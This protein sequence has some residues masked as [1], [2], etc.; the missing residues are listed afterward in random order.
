MYCPSC[1]S[2]VAHGLTYCNQC[3][4]KLAPTQTDIAKTTEVSDSLVWAIVAI[5][6]VG[7][8]ATIGLMAVM[9]NELHFDT[10]LILFF[11]I[12]SF[13]LMTGIEAVFIWMLLRRTRSPKDAT[14]IG[15]KQKETKELAGAP[16]R[17]LAEPMASV[18]EETTRAF[19]PVYEKRK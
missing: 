15:R 2:A 6:V 14:A 7:I 18:T 12:L 13:A 10:S 9:K 3:G 16:H 8:G 1:G 11:S 17:V 19:Q 5:F 4:A